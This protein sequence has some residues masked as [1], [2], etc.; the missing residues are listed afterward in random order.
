MNQEKPIKLL[1]IEDEVIVRTC[2][3]AYFQDMGCTVFEAGNGKVGLD[4]FH[5]EQPDV[6][7]CDLRM[8]VMDGF[9]VIEVIRNESP[10]TPLI[11]VSGNGQVQD[12]VKAMRAGAWDYVEKPIRDLDELELAVIKGLDRAA[13]VKENRMYREHLEEE[14][15]KRTAELV[16]ETAERKRAHEQVESLRLQQMLMDSIPTPTFYQDLNGICQIAN[17]ALANFL[18]KPKSDLVGC[19]CSDLLS[20]ET[21]VEDVPYLLETNGGVHAYETRVLNGHQVLRDV[22]VHKT[23][24]NDDSGEPIGIS[25]TYQDITERKELEEQ[26]L[27]ELSSNLSIFET[28]PALLLVLDHNGKILRF[29]PACEKAT[30]YATSMCI[31]LRFQD[32][33][34]TEDHEAELNATLK[35]AIDSKHKITQEFNFIA[36][37]KQELWI[38]WSFSMLKSKQTNT[39]G[40]ETIIAVGLNTTKQKHLIHSLEDHREHLGELVTART[41]E[42]I[43]AKDMADAA[44]KAKSD[45]LANMSHEIRTPMNG[46][47]GMTNLLC[48]TE[49]SSKQQGYADTIK[50]SADSLLSIIN[51][52]LDFSKIEAGKLDIS[53][54]PFNLEAMVADVIELFKGKVAEKNIT[55][56]LDLNRSLPMDLIGDS[57][58]IRQI[59]ANLISNAIKFTS[60]GGVEVIIIPESTES[61]NEK[62]TIYFSVIDT[63]IGIDAV[64]QGMVFDKFTQEEASTTRKYGGTGLGLA[65]SKQLSELMGGTI[66]VES[67]KNNGSVF[68]FKIPL[69]INTDTTTFESEETTKQLEHDAM[70]HSFAGSRV[71]LVED[72]KV[73]QIVATEVLEDFGCVVDIAGNGQEGVNLFCSNDYDLILMDCSMP[74]LDGFSATSIIR[75]KESEQGKSCTGTPIVAMT[76]LAMDGDKGRCL[77]S[78]MNDYISKPIEAG[79]IYKFLVKFLKPTV[80]DSAM[81]VTIS[82]DNTI[83]NSRYTPGIDYPKLQKRFKNN[84]VIIVEILNQV[85]TDCSN[86]TSNIKEA[87]KEKD[88][89]KGARTAHSLKSAAAQIMAKGLEKICSSIEKSFFAENISE[90]ENDLTTLDTELSQ[91]IQS[92]SAII[93]NRETDEYSR[94][95]PDLTPERVADINYCLSDLTGSLQKRAP[96]LTEKSL[97]KLLENLGDRDKTVKAL[98]NAIRNYEFAEAL[99]HVNNLQKEIEERIK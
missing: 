70:H 74:V 51:D 83:V 20:C 55:L 71:L 31:G 26:L 73:N 33:F 64:K 32:L 14:V 41:S 1:T 34:I 36:R 92:C 39:G 4:I 6:V 7:L 30:G 18:N 44:N 98:Q 9:E 80:A 60:K 99:E 63:G 12:T 49:L 56:K 82:S 43:H 79:E 16:A 84:K 29:N 13:L 94:P 67:S 25:V 61:N 27:K 91:V 87:I 86:A 48:A 3:V 62:I 53:P 89:D 65:I 35:N 24:M 58:R 69:T 40:N 90:V 8:P 5:K 38:S 22:L 76:A 10:E 50:N 54:H 17:E 85:L 28:A 81:P 19:A 96:I 93:N 72:N 21:S 2:I 45:F 57:G 68:W 88:I 75:E 78:G 97:D 77:K 59:L 42:L 46:V 52:I 15:E 11:V 47:L 66:G 95:A 23:R 37:D